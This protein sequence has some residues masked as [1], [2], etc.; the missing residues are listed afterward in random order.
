MKKRTKIIFLVIAI[1]VIIFIVAVAFKVKS[2]LKQEEELV[3]ELDSLYALLDHYPLDYE[4]LDRKI[5]TTVTTDDYAKVEKA[6]KEYSKDFVSYMKQFDTLVND[7]TIKNAVGIDNIKKD[8]PD[9]TNTKQKLSES[10]TSLDAIITDFSNYLTEETAMSYIKDSGLNEYY[11]DF[12]KQYIL[13]DSLYEM[14]SSKDEIL[15]SLNTIKLLIEAEEET[16]DFLAENKESWKVENDQLLFYS[17]SLLN[18]Y[19]SIISKYQ[20]LVSKAKE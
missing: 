13:G 6:V 7:E 8:G 14:E 19:N 11:T 17:E 12:Y 3:E 10:K 9:F 5:S 2:D 15:D 1:F 4:S 18:Q 20:N 16:I